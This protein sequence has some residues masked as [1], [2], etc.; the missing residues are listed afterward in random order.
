[1]AIIPI[2]L[3]PTIFTQRSALAV[4]SPAYTVMQPNS[5][6][7]TQP[8]VSLGFYFTVDEPGYYVNALGLYK[9]DGWLL[10]NNSYNVKLWSFVNG[11]LD[12]QDYSPV[13]LTPLVFDPADVAT[14]TE[15]DSWYFQF[16]PQPIELPVTL[17]A[18]EKG[19]LIA[20]WGDYTM[21]GNSSK[22]GGAYSFVPEISY[23]KPPAIS[24]NTL[25]DF[26]IPLSTAPP[27]PDTGYWNA[28]LSLVP[29]PL[30]VM[31]AAVGYGMA[32]R[33]RQRIRAI[34]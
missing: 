30:P 10:T 23:F 2:L 31:G 13:T 8:L 20:A 25:P 11:G 12:A 17:E 33:L 22:S 18:E 21:V 19:Y 34:R 24:N 14:Y 28:N 32:R 1:M 16:L 6:H 5:G 4:I 29:G 7:F 15:V 26:P 27:Y 9:Q 3:G